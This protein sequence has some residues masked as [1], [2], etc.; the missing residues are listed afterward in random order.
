MNTKP[1]LP[2]IKEAGRHYWNSQP[3]VL[4]DYTDN[5]FLHLLLHSLEPVPIYL[6]SNPS[7]D[8]VPVCVC[9]CVAEWCEFTPYEVGLPKYGAFVPTEDF[10]SE[11][12]LGHQ[13]KKLP[14]TRLP[15]MIGEIWNEARREE[16]CVCLCVCERES[17]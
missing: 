8:S 6:T 4:G 10:G 7:L 13:V 17:V 15:F 16:G 3:N 5:V 1:S 14:E 12:F 9:V 2:G 11:Y